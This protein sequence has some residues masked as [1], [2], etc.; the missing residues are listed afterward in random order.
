MSEN[1]SE[2]I[3]TFRE[4]KKKL[5]FEEQKKILGVDYLLSDLIDK[6]IEVVAVDD[7]NNI[8]TGNLEGR[9]VR[10]LVNSKVVSAEIPRIQKGIKLFGRVLITPREKKSKNGRT[11]I[12]LE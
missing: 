6:Q 11:Y 10:I 3:P 8:L 7:I 5:Q 9:K 4:L 12:K 2:H 1:S